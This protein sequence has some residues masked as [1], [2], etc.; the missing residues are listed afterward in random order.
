MPFFL[1]AV[2]I[3]KFMD[4]HLYGFATA[5]IS[6][7]TKWI[8]EQ[9]NDDVHKEYSSIKFAAAA[10]QDIASDG[11]LDGKDH[12]TY[13]IRDEGF[14]GSNPDPFNLLTTGL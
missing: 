2:A 1:P 9:N 10:Y 6:Q 4:Q 11:Q 3:E 14:A 8:S 7:L 5:S 12:Y 13:S